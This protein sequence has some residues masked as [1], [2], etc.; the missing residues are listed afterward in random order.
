MKVKLGTKPSFVF[1]SILGSRNLVQKKLCW[2]V[3][4]GQKIS[5][6]TDPWIPGIPNL[7]A[8]ITL[9]KIKMSRSLV[10]LLLKE[11]GM[12]MLSANSL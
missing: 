8:G 12:R 1:R 6:C 5:A 3:G 9:S 4:D 2:R 11:L 10:S 7:Q